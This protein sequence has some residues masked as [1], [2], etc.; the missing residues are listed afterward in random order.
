M[1]E[2]SIDDLLERSPAFAAASR[3]FKLRIIWS[4]IGGVSTIVGLVP[5]AHWLSALLSGLFPRIPLWAWQ[6]SFVIGGVAG[7]W[8][9]LSIPNIVARRLFPP[10]ARRFLEV[11]LETGIAVN[12]L[13]VYGVRKPKFNPPVGR[14]MVEVTDRPDALRGYRYDRARG[15]FAPTTERAA[16][17]L[18]G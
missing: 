15:I 11:D 8:W 7:M 10:R 3:R 17:S 6:W 4:L 2:D 18:P 1:P 5:A 12:E 9:A 13:E 14:L 16:P